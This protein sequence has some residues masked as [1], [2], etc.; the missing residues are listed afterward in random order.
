MNDKQIYWNQHLAAQQAS[1]LGVKAYC[2]RESLNYATFQSWRAKC[3][4]KKASPLIPVQIKSINDLPVAICTLV[5]RD[6][7]R[8]E[9]HDSV[10]LKEMLARYL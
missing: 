3:R 8:I 9:F 4:E 10:F 7:A 1:D 5:L 2:S 6:G